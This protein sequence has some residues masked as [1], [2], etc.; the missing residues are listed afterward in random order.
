MTQVRFG[1]IGIGNMGSA[2]ATSIT[3]GQVP[4]LQLVAVADRRASRR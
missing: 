4:E 2:H 1:I 3:G